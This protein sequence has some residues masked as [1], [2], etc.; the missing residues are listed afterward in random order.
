V[1]QIAQTPGIGGT[2]QYGYVREI[3]RQVKQP[4]G[5]RA[6]CEHERLIGQCRARTQAD[7]PLATIY[8][9]GRIAAM[10]LDAGISEPALRAVRLQ[11]LSRVLDEGFRKRRAVVR[12]LGFFAHEV[13]AARTACGSKRVAQLCG[14]V[15]A[16]DDDDAVRHVAMLHR[17]FRRIGFVSSLETDELWSPL[18]TYTGMLRGLIADVAFLFCRCAPS[19]AA[20]ATGTIADSGNGETLLALISQ[21]T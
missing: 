9:N 2:A 5:P 12:Q 20:R 8:S 6:G 13:Y 14:R 16:A 15:S 17:S 4:S 18:G 7:P 11:T 21:S 3:L 1:Q 10:D 19:T